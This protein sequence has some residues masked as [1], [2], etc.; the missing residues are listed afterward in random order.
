MTKVHLR[1]NLKNMKKQV[2]FYK[3]SSGKCPTREFLDSLPTK[4]AHKMIWT[5]NLIE[6]MNGVP[7]VYF[8]K[9]SGTNDIWECRTK[10]GSNI[11][12]IF[13]FLD[14]DKVILSHGIVKKTQ[15]TPP[16]EI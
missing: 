7:A 6:D 8:S 9:M 3:T 14:K 10:L 4:S 15:K 1:V 5:L 13:A 11:Y 12:R 16:G 2:I